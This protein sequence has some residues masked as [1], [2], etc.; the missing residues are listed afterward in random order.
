[1]AGELQLDLVQHPVQSGDVYLLCSDGLTGAI[2]DEELAALLRKS[3]ADLRD[4]AH[5]AVALANSR[6][7][8]DNISIVLM[9]IV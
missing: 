8:R 5:E 4:L 3:D 2:G 9:R 7:G 1:M 6:G